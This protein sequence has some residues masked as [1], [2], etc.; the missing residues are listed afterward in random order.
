MKA[1]LQ[2]RCHKKRKVCIFSKFTRGLFFRGNQHLYL[3]PVSLCTRGFLCVCVLCRWC[4]ENMSAS[5]CNH[6]YGLSSSDVCCWDP[7]ELKIAAS[8]TDTH[9]NRMMLRTLALNYLGCEDWTLLWFALCLLL[10]H[11]RDSKE[12]QSWIEL[13][14]CSI[15]M[16]GVHGSRTL[17]KVP[18]AKIA[19]V[20]YFL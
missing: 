4:E 6:R 8:V 7:P 2:Q 3:K 1:L 14:C 18:Q 19:L 16:N 11:S 10:Y 13:N 15:P 12:E 5:E 17:P 20:S 9:L